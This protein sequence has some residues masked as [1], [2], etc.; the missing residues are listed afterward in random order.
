M[1]HKPSNS[2]QM[3]RPES[4][5]ADRDEQRENSGL[6]ERDKQEFAAQQSERQHERQP[7]PPKA[8]DELDPGE[9]PAREPGADPASGTARRD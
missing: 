6:L 2:Y 4:G 9:A 7:V 8:K 5:G 1:G 3:N